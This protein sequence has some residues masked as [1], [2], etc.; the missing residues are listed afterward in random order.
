MSKGRPDSFNA[1]TSPSMTVLSGRSARASKAR[2]YCLLKDFRR[3]EKRFSVP[4]D[5]AAMARYP[6]SFDLVHP[7]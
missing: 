5:F 3:L 1:T 4:D 2:E 6:S 7:L